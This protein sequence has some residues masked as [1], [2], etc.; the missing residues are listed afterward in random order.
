[1]RRD[2]LPFNVALALQSEQMLRSLATLPKSA[3]LLYMLSWR[4]IRI[5]Y[6]Q[7]AMGFLWAILTPTL[8]VGAALVVRVGVARLRG[9][10][11]T[12]ED[13]SSIALRAITWTFFSS[14]VRFGTNSLLGN[15]SLVTKIFFPREVFPLAAMMSSL[16]D[17]AIAGAAAL[18]LLVILG[19]VPSVHVLW[20]FIF[21]YTLMAFTAGLTLLLSAANLFFRDVKYL[22]DIV[23]TYAI[24]LT[25]VLYDAS[26][27]GKWQGLLM[28]NPLSPIL[29]GLVQSVVRHQS[30]D[31][32]WTMYGV[33]V[34]TVV[35][36]MG[37]WSFKKLETR[38][39]ESI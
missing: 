18:V 22:V 6:K 39:A 34:A 15:S 23:L 27:V 3:E 31:P 20:A 33:V 19:W 4:D 25:P 30:P 2:G 37:Y 21:L 5:R 38:F 11:V 13:I 9:D 8:V 14:A 7:S 28:L 10:A 1:M 16:F 17:F 12:N 26:F 36:V 29:E 32:F 35:L 24:F